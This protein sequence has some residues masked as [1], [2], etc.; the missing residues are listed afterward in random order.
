M[1]PRVTAILVV[2]N[3]E[4]WLDRTLAAV[5]GQTRRPDDLIVV[6]AGSGVDIAA[7][8]AATAVPTRFV[9][10]P[11][12][13]FAAGIDHGVRA[14]GATQ[15]PNEWLW[16]LTADTA[17]DPSALQRLLA[18]LEL[19][20]SVAIAG[21]KLVDVDDPAILVSYGE[22]I[23]MFG[24]TVPLVDG[25]LDQAQYDT[26]GDVL[27]VS[28]SAMLV[29][30][31]TWEELGG[32]DP[33]LPT[34]DAGLDLSIRARLSGARVV[35]VPD[36]RVA[37][38]ARV[39]DFGRR[40][41][42]SERG[43]AGVRRQ[44]QL[45]RR[46]VYAPASAL[47]FLWLSLVPIA[48]LRSIGHLLGKR[49]GL[50]GGE[51]ASG[52][53]AA[54]DGS[55]PAARRRLASVRKVGW[56]ALASLRI[57]SD[58][59]RERR[60]AARERRP[61]RLNE[62]ELV[63]ASFLSGGGAWVVMAAAV[64]GLILS[65]RYL[66]ENI[67][68]GGALLP[69]NGDVA[70]LW[71]QLLAGPREGAV[72]LTG[73][74]DPFVGVLATLGSLTFWNPSFSMVLLWIIALPLAALGA[75]WCATRLSERRWPPIVAALL[76]MLAPPL[77]IALGE[78]RPTGVLAHLLLPWL[79]LAGIESAKSWAA[80]AT[81]SLLFAATVASAPSLTPVLVVLVVV[82][83]A[84]HPRGIPRIVGIV[85]PAAALFAPLVIAQTMR[86]TPLALFADPG[87]AVPSGAVSGWQLLLG[88]PATGSSTW[89]GFATAAGLPSELGILAPAALLAPLA[90]VGL[91]SLFLPGAR[92]SVP[93]LVVAL[94]GLLTAVAASHFTVAAAGVDG[95]TPWPGA[96]LSLYWLGL[97]GAVVV[98]LEALRRAA[99]LTGMAV[100]LT[101]AAAVAPFAAASAVGGSPVVVSNG[102]LLPALVGAQ[103]DSDPD[104][105][106][107]VL[108]AQPDGSLRATLMRGAGTTLDETSSLVSTRVDIR[109][110]DAPLTELV[111]N[112]ASLSGYD[113]GP[114]LQKLQVAFIVVP[115]ASGPAA[116]VR[117]RTAEALDA[118]AN[119]APVGDTALW[120]FPALTE[121]PLP[122]TAVGPIGTVAPWVQ[123]AIVAIALL[124]AIP[125]RRR[126]RS[127]RTTGPLDED[128]ADTF[129]EDDNA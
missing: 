91:L 113:P 51:L 108:T 107:L 56:Q 16:L 44:A 90:L 13:T 123:L 72:D 69:L 120:R 86:G 101:A 68:V 52:F 29:R 36:A 50:I 122:A 60:A 92:R 42:L 79:L 30:R 87:L 111:A 9:A 71:S 80:A 64:A 104:L 25:E 98:G 1:Q 112:L 103:A 75:W 21:P 34:A 8:V 89:L 125:T 66:G 17:P 19:A 88:Q 67:I 32:F 14:A 121:A 81:A 105:G 102:R 110:E 11:A 118:S 65:W 93:A 18:A 6:D 126:R 48:F 55:V 97:V 78:G 53:A 24:T 117:Q 39:E 73:P 35:R 63:R 74:A 41:P 114:E 115:A 128:P 83:A 116:A 27:G 22:S 119:L 12:T 129:D 20:P 84:T 96:G 127:V 31:T 62:Q 99:V 2:R 37:R 10:A 43:L 94:L 85:I 77:L 95:V 3:G 124:L 54:F 58:E 57:P 7:Q 47:V 82:W 28:Q 33:G 4:P 46:L 49:P 109:E 61:D 23:S 38:G 45:H 100:V 5:H 59:Q 106:T 40:K 76:W 15:G 26:V 70:T